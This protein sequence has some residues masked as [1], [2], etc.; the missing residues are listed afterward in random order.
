MNG[1]S[2]QARASGV[3]LPKYPYP[4]LR[5]FQAE[6]WPIF[7]GREA[8]IDEVIDRLAAHRL[9]LIHGASGA[10]KSSLVRAGVLPKLER[11]HRRAG[12]S[13]QTCT[14]RPSGGPLW[15]LAGE[16]AR[17]QGAA[18][19]AERASRIVGQFN[20]RGATLSSVAGTLPELAGQRLCVLVDQFEELFRFERES[21]REEAEAFVDLLV[22]SSAE[23][24][25]KDSAGTTREAVPVHLIVTMRSEFLG[26][27]ARFEGLAEA[28]N[29]TQYLVPRMQ[30]DA[31]LR[32]VRRP[33]Q[34]Y[35][36]EVTLDL[37]ERLIADAAGRG[38]ELP[39]IQ[40][41]LMLMWHEAA[42][43]VA[44]AGKI[45]L[46][47]T[48]LEAVGDLGKLLSRHA[49][50]TVDAAAPD[51]T[52]RHAVERLFRALTD[53]NVEGR[54]IR[55]PQVF[56]DLLAVTEINEEKL[57]EIIDA[58]RADGVSFITPYPPQPIGADTPIDISHEALIRCWDRLSNRQTG[59]LK[60]EFDDGLIWRSL[61]VEAKGF[62]DNSRHVLSE[63]T[64]VERRD[65]WRDRKVNA[66]WAERY[67]GNFNLVSEL[68]DASQR[69]AQRKRHLRQA[70]IAMLLL[71]S[72]AGVAYAAWTNQVR[73][74]MLADL[75]VRGTVLST[76]KERELKPLSSFQECS[77]CPQMVVVPSGTFKMGSA[78]TDALADLN[79]FPQHEIT[80]AQTFAISKFP[81]TFANWDACYEL[82]GC[83]IRPDDYG[84]EGGNRPVILV[85][86]NDAEEYVSWLSKQTGKQYRLLT[87]AE[88]E[89]A[90]RAGTTTAYYWGDD[91]KK[92]GV[93]IADCFACGSRWDDKQTAPVG[94][95]A[96]NAFGLND[97]A[98]NVWEW[99]EDCYHENYNSAPTDGSAWIGSNCNRRVIRGGSWGD[100]P[101]N[102]RSAARVGGPIGNRYDGLG[103]R[104]ARTL[105][106]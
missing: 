72:S 85:D 97:M 91:V 48:P 44:Y 14:I 67:G 4:G 84:W 106:H 71:I 53:L 61:L 38:D 40:H 56:R 36:G 12:A 99:V 49:D 1:S 5:P 95:F 52:C 73:L 3:T 82:H 10:G 93:A 75:Y 35:R 69:S 22:R 34:L 51:P 42:S 86:W 15:N 94:S 17:L 43:R 81:I 16:F 39:L 24:S 87:E 57:R 2:A 41:G 80:I 26:E 90:A 47:A 31:L 29:R 64:T 7:F 100:P 60:Q 18:D 83:R 55:R 20:G 66:A 28:I 96:P 30:R 76:G 54:A 8:M 46:D 37:A 103:F 89:Y 104:V 33:A 98:G 88:W 101:E 9:V 32:A 27:C 45:V 23:V 70:L 25:A 58:L 50:A 77:R 92:G 6:E 65:W 21:S 13:W 68:I 62:E 74:Q 102:L 59:W 19:D 79:E 63:A 78:S 105:E 11:Q